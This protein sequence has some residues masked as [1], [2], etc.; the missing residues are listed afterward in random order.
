M[1]LFS[2]PLF[3]IAAL[4]LPVLFV[5]YKFRNQPKTQ[6]VSSLMLWDFQKQ[7]DTG[8]RVLK[9]LPLP[10]TL[11]LEL[12]IL[13]MLVIAAATPLVLSSQTPP[14]LVII[15]DNSY[16][17]LAGGESSAHA[18]AKQV[19]SEELK[20][21]ARRSISF[22]L[23]GKEI[24]TLGN[25]TNN[26]SVALKQLDAWLCHAPESDLDKAIAFT[27]KMY[28][29]QT[30]IL[31]VSDKLPENN[32]IP[33]GI[34]WVSLGSPLPNTAFTN[35]TRTNYGATERYLFEISNLSKNTTRT[36]LSLQF[37]NSQASPQSR[38]VTLGP[39]E[40]KKIIMEL[41]ISLRPITATLK[42]DAL[43]LDNSVFL[44]PQTKTTIKIK[45]D[46]SDTSI[47]KMVKKALKNTGT[48]FSISDPELI[49]TDKNTSV[50][51]DSTSWV[52]NI[53]PVK[54]GNAYT[55]PFIIEKTNPLT[56]GVFLNSVI[57]GGSAKV[58]LPGTPLITA[59][60]IPLLTEK[61]YNNNSRTYHLQ[62]A[63][64]LSNI[65]NSPAWPI[66]IWNLIEQRR[67]HLPGP[68]RNNYRLGEQAHISLKPNTVKVNVTDP[69]NITNK[70]NPESG[71]LIIHLNKPGTWTLTALNETYRI[72]VNTLSYDESDL[73][74]R[75]EKTI[76]NRQEAL[77]TH[78]E[79]RSIAWIF[80]I[81]ALVGFTGHL[82]LIKTSVP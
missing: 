30:E 47:M 13:A 45:L 82:Y 22:I 31:V 64:D 20:Q 66:M 26:A 34:K 58:H 79:Y 1:P 69:D 44:M 52:L 36:T 6:I 23:A 10:L 17:M 74:K 15:L 41:P 63:P 51:P 14:P 40:T 24:S 57:W 21:H 42:D 19:I 68:T 33:S 4:S 46:I 25:R 76:D 39:T 80:L 3:F 35:A 67:L 54:K 16:S 18:K 71:Q 12:F 59:A 7:P 8:G 61:K 50:E 60:N 73:S 53:E 27:R 9:K 28:H 75:V 56:E 38:P 70:L 43:S 48:T 72:C 55:G 65:I 11:F 32:E 77:S 62:I 29:K 49:I 5:I 37:K 2:F 78:D 81:I